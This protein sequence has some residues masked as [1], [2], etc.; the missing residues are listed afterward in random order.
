MASTATSSRGL[1]S[2]TLA[3]VRRPLTSMNG[4]S[5]PATTCAL[6]MTRPGANTKPEPS[7]PR[8]QDA[9]PMT[10]TTLSDA[11]LTPGSRRVASSGG[12]TAVMRSSS[13]GSM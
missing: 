2:T 4:S 11:C 7:T 5:T 9:T 13:N 10:L 8:S 1:N 12:S 3:R 6:V